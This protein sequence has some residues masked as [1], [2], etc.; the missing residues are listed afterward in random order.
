LDAFDRHVP[1]GRELCAVQSHPLFRAH[2]AG[3]F[4]LALAAPGI[5]KAV[6]GLGISYDTSNFSRDQRL[7]ALAL[8][9]GTIDAHAVV[10]RSGNCCLWANYLFYFTKNCEQRRLTVK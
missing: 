8:A 7:D 9:C 2:R 5:G 1:V 10:A 3:S 6:S 4:C